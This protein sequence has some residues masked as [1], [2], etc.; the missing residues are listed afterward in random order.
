MSK[1]VSVTVGASALG[2][3]VGAMLAKTGR[4][5]AGPRDRTCSA[6]R[7]GSACWIT[8]VRIDAAKGLFK[9][10]FTSKDCRAV[11]FSTV[12]MIATPI[13]LSRSLLP[14]VSVMDI[15]TW[16]GETPIVLEKLPIIFSWTFGFLSVVMFALQAA[17]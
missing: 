14:G 8:T 16:E 13:G 5:S 15:F 12:I 9:T 3:R 17:F 6:E 4:A 10:A 11:I 7:L 2:L 1:L